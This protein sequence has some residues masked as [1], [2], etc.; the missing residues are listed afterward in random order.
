M[1]LLEILNSPD[2]SLD[3]MERY[4]NKGSPS[5]FTAKYR[6]K[7]KTDPMGN[8]S[9]FCPFFIFANQKDF[10]DYGFIPK[11][12]GCNPPC[13][14][15]VKWIMLHPNTVETLG[16]QNNKEVK[17][18]EKIRVIPTAS[19]RTVRVDGE[20]IYFKLHYEGV[21]GRVY[22]ELPFEKAV[23]GPELST[24]LRKSIKCFPAKFAF[25]DEIGCRTINLK[26][27]GKD[28]E[29]GMVVRKK[30]P[31]CLYPE[32]IK[33]IIPY[34]SLFSL[35]TNNKSDSL[36]LEQISKFR[37]K[38]IYDLVLDEILFPIIESYFY[39]IHNH[40]FIPEWNAQNL[41]IGFDDDF[42]NPYIICRDLQRIEK[43]LT[44]R[45]SSGFSNN[46]QSKN[47]KSIHDGMDVYQIRHSFSFDFKLCEYVIE[48]LIHLIEKDNP[49]RAK[50]AREK[51]KNYVNENIIKLPKNYFPK[52][53]WYKHD[54]IILTKIR[55]YVELKSPR[56]RD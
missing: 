53:V 48:P 14:D 1:K 32:K 8:T 35:D 33:N 36:L 15:E 47:Y 10:V 4:V 2:S 39:L 24:E 18:N 31:V 19:S 43:D 52:K 5:G 30:T 38:N 46:F 13:K 23:A 29:I 55:P 42:K 11:L 7:G 9:S 40:G 34:F 20:E 28:K 12:I 26:I 21:L 6:G 3:Y 17:E 54:D 16:L 27:D 41:L 49:S 50:Q 51:I 56:Y 22:R 45:S 25:M 37:K 44:I